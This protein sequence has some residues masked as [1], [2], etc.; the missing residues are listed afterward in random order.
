MLCKSL[1]LW[2]PC[3]SN[4][5]SMLSAQTPTKFGKLRIIANVFR[6]K[7]CISKDLF[8]GLLI[9]S[10]K[11]STRKHN[12]SFSTR[13]PLLIEGSTR[14]LG[15]NKRCRL[16]IKHFS[17]DLSF[18]IVDETII[19]NNFEFGNFNVLLGDKQVQPH[20]PQFQM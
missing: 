8:T 17:I 7:I 11:D 2:R 16:F 13:K 15:A 19:S 18:F 1:T 5:I 10:S 14:P 3:L 12:Y 6:T 20:T 9:N 4:I